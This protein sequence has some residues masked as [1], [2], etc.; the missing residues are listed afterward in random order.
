MADGRRL[1]NVIV[2]GSVTT[3]PALLLV[4]RSLGLRHNPYTTAKQN[5]IYPRIIYWLSKTTSTS[6]RR[7]YLLAT[8]SSSGMSSSAP[9]LVAE[10]DEVGSSRPVRARM[11]DEPYS[12]VAISLTD[13]T[14]KA[15][16]AASCTRLLLLWA[17]LPKRFRLEEFNTL[18]DASPPLS[19][20]P[21]RSL[22]L[23][24]ANAALLHVVLQGIFEALS[25]SPS[26]TLTFP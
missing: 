25:L 18:L 24:H 9:S 13:T 11:A 17:V 6:T 12:R 21:C 16:V 19:S 2:A 10:D 15:G 4:Y 1:R 23:V 8:L 22:P 7:K 3:R 20:V 5:Y 14:N 26:V